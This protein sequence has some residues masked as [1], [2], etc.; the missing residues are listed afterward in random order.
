[1]MRSGLTVGNTMSPAGSFDAGDEA[2]RM[3]FE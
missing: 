1:M 3:V 2:R